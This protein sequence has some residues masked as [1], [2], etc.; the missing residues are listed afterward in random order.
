MPDALSCMYGY[1]TDAKLA[2]IELAEETT[3]AWY[4]ARFSSVATSPT[5][6]RYCKIVHGHLYIYR[7]E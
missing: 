7:I 4:K 1:E 6:H 2:S 3:D 5:D